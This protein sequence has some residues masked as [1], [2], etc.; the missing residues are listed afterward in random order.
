MIGVAC[1]SATTLGEREELGRAVALARAQRV[2]PVADHR[3]RDGLLRVRRLAGRLSPQP[4]R[5]ASGA[6][7]DREAA[8]HAHDHPSSVQD[9]G[10][11]PRPRSSLGAMR[12]RLRGRRRG[13]VPADGSTRRRPPA[14]GRGGVQGVPAR[15]PLEP[16]R[17]LRCRWRA[18]RTAWCAASGSARAC[19]R[20]S[21]RDCTKAGR[22]ASRSRPSGA[23]QR[24]VHVSF[25]YADESDRRRYPIP[26]DAPVEG[27]RG[28]DGDRHVIVVDRD[29]CRLYELYA[30]YP[31]NGGQRWRA[32][33]GAIW[34]LRSNRLRPAGWTSADAAGL[35]ILPGLAR[36]EEVRRG[37]ID[38]ALRFTASQTRRAYVYPARHFASSCDR[39]GAAADGPAR[40]AARELRHRGLRASR[41]ASCCRRSSATG[42]SSP[43]TAHRGTSAARPSRGWDNDDLHGLRPRAGQRLRGRR[44]VLA[45]ATRPVS[46]HGTVRATRWPATSSLPRPGVVERRVHSRAVAL[47]GRPEPRITCLPQR[48]GPVFPFIARAQPPVAAVNQRTLP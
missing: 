23:R 25:D 1:R 6:E 27:G 12:S 10:R 19:T 30:A 43:T 7:G 33:S 44:H 20:T 4:P 38:H 22:S 11:P 39:P 8:A 16:A 24:K 32:G 29:R 26:R 42:C 34:S 41:R 14:E 2:G 47:R 36:Y 46:A 40:A 37:E 18:T 48:H 28:S 31:V 9:R 13:R 5:P 21:A 35:P 3:C 17:R 45:A 15:Q